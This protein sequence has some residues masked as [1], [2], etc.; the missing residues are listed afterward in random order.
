MGKAGSS[1]GREVHTKLLW[2]NLEERD[3][4]KELDIDG[5]IKMESHRNRT[6]GVCAGFTWLRVETSGTFL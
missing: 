4:S 1:D 6:G 3:H 2:E 5:R